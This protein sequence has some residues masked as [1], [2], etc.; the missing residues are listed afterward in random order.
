MA[1]ELRK[2]L[3]TVLRLILIVMTLGSAVL[4]FSTEKEGILRES[5]AITVAH[6]VLDATNSKMVSEMNGIYIA[7]LQFYTE[8][9]KY[10]GVL[11]NFAERLGY[12][13]LGL[14]KEDRST[15]FPINLHQ[16]WTEEIK[17]AYIALNVFLSESS[18]TK[19]LFDFLVAHSNGIT[20]I[21][22]Y[23]GTVLK[24]GMPWHRDNHAKHISGWWFRVPLSFIID[25][26]FFGK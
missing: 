22:F 20:R 10:G 4:I 7:I 5:G 17:Q 13:P 24:K 26:V 2:D 11:K 23:G 8:N 21:H 15:G 1:M 18:T 12:F 14:K 6:E 3:H 19:E 9:E 25:T 16:M